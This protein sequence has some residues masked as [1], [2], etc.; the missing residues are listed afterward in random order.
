M[1]AWGS[2]EN[3]IASDVPAILSKTRSIYRLNDNE[4]VVLKRD[5]VQVYNLDLE[6]VLK[7]KV[8]I[9]WDISAAEKGGYEHFMAKEIMEQPKAVHD[10]ISPRLKD[11]RIVLDDITLT[12]EEIDRFSKISIVACGSAYHVG[13]V[14]IVYFGADTHSVEVDVAS[15]FR[16][17]RTNHQ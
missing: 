15:K 3:F 6:P 10:T 5:S 1:L 14:A 17:R 16:Y 12:K 2:I 4:I 7:E 8:H 11:G 9:D 13:V